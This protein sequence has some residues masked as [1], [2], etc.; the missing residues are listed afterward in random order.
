MAYDSRTLTGVGGWLAFFIII[1]AVFSP[2]RAIL[3]TATLHG[4]PSISTAFGDAW[5]PMITIEWLITAAQIG[6]FWFVAW[7]LNSVHEWQSVRVAIAGIW[8]VPLVGY[9]LELAAAS[10]IG[11]FALG[12]ILP[13]A[14]PDLGR[15]IIFGGIWTAYLLRSERVA[16]TYG[17]SPETE[18]VAGVFD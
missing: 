12:D 2:L 9:V 14:L 18:G 16:N 3:A 17:K 1:L 11:G 4:D 10:F 8:V 15:S 13:G 5:G 7:R 6:A